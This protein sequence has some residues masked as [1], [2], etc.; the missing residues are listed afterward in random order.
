[1]ITREDIDK[2]AERIDGRVRRTPVV[3][4]GA[5]AFGVDARLTLKL[6]LLQH[7]GSFKPRGAFNRILAAGGDVRGVIAASGGNHG[8]GVAYAARVLG[9]PAEIFVPESASPVKVARLRALGA[10]VTVTGAFYADAYAA[11][12]ERAAH[13]GAL[14]VHAYDQPEVA[15][16][17]GTIAR[18]LADQAPDLDTVVVA[19]GGG[20]L[21]AGIATWFGPA[22]AGDL[23][24]ADLGAE[25]IGPAGLGTGER[26][27]SPV[28]IVAVE[29]ERT[30]TLASAL[31]AGEPVD[32]EVGG[33]AADALGARRIGSEGFAAAV[34]AEVTSLLVSDDAVVAARQALWDELR[35]AAEPA[36]AAAL[37]ALRTGAYRPDPGERVA[38]IV[39]G[40]NSDPAGLA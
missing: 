21:L 3:D 40:G 27:G 25:E 35:V 39:C 5:G 31:A 15:A 8:L 18:E 11:S 4:P 38:V 29:T 20:G 19:V 34:R 1:V 7:A 32:V 6:E 28:R 36:G 33:V 14:V 2:A 22:Q 17:Q 16:G 37:A 12:Q 24:P 10:R 26:G 9:I 30:P 23:G 13:T